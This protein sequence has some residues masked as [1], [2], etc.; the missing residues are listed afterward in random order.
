M[1]L[2][3]MVVY[4]VS[5]EEHPWG[6]FISQPSRVGTHLR[7]VFT[8]GGC[9]LKNHDISVFIVTAFNDLFQPNCKLNYFALNDYDQNNLQQ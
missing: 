7:E 6:S 2:G 3:S 4:H 9:S 5:S 1:L 8:Q